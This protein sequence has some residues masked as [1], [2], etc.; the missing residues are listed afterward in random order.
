V[1]ASRRFYETVA[2]VLSHSNSVRAGREARVHVL[3]ADRSFCLLAGPPTENVHLASPVPDDGTVDEFHR[4][5][6]AA[7]YRDNGVPGERLGR[8]GYAVRSSSIR[9]AA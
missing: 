5:A 2:P 7:G 9:I 1:D 8:A 6:R 3:A 4:V